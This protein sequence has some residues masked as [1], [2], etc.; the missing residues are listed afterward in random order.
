MERVEVRTS[1]KA[2]RNGFFAALFIIVLS[3]IFLV[4]LRSGILGTILALALLLCGLYILIS[5]KKTKEVI[6]YI[7]DDVGL[8][9]HL[10]KGRYAILY[11]SNIELEGHGVFKIN[12]ILH[13][14]F[15]LRDVESYTKQLDGINKFVAKR[16]YRGLTGTEVTLPIENYTVSPDMFLEMVGQRVSSY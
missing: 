16:F 14:S 10:G 8:H 13:V 1:D 3:L 4:F 9:I 6:V 5:L 7:F 11:W 12:G 2:I 15:K